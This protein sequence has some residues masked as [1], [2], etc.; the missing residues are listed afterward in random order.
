[1][2]MANDGRRQSPTGGACVRCRDKKL[3]C[4]SRRPRCGTCISAN[5]D[6][7]PAAPQVRR[8]PKKGYLKTLQDQVARLE[9]QLAEAHG[10]KDP[11]VKPPESLSSPLHIDLDSLP[12]DLEPGTSGPDFAHQ[13]AYPQFENLITPPAELGLSQ[14]L[15]G[16]EW[17]SIGSSPELLM[18]SL[19]AGTV[20]TDPWHLTG[21]DDNFNFAEGTGQP[22]TVARKYSDPSLLQADFTWSAAIST[23]S[24]RTQKDTDWLEQQRHTRLPLAEDTFQNSEPSEARYLHDLFEGQPA[25]PG[26]SP[27][28]ELIVFCTISR[29]IA[30]FK[31]D[32]LDSHSFPLVL[33]AR[34]LYSHHSQLTKMLDLRTEALRASSSP[35]SLCS[36]PIL[37]FVRMFS[38]ALELCLC[39][40]FKKVYQANAEGIDTVIPAWQ[41]RASKAVSSVIGF[42]SF[43]ASLS[44]FKVH[45][46]TPLPLAICR[47]FLEIGQWEDSTTQPNIQEITRMLH[48]MASINNLASEYLA[49]TRTCHGAD[50]S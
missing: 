24:E 5:A 43:I 21:P 1:M 44:Y 8:G 48:E 30:S 33:P 19:S 13:D 16:T 37:L 31:R 46:F 15:Q 40:S 2:D 45:P 36:D 47:D 50:V 20:S 14:S 34:D 25:L 27:F 39:N 4:D 42:S 18:S 12:M 9:Q 49:E 3:K 38:N 41:D 29:H 10:S 6:C 35:P 28:V 22:S 23:L 32:R 17:P 7:E 11:V 26:R